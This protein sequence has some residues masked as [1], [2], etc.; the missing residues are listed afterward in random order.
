MN[1]V[2]PNSVTVSGSRSLTVVGGPRLPI[3]M[4]GSALNLYALAYEAA[5]MT[6]AAESRRGWDRHSGTSC[7]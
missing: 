1:L 6:V 2:P 3:P 7:N 5:R 4:C